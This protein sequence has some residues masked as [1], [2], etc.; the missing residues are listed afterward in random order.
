M[1]TLRHVGGVLTSRCWFVVF[2]LLLGVSLLT[3]GCQRE[4]R[5]ESSVLMRIGDRTITVDEYQRDFNLYR[6]ATGAGPGEDAAGDRE[7]QIRFVRQ[8]VDQLVLLEHARTIGIDVT[9]QELATALEAI[10]RD[11]PD[12]VFEQLLLENAVTLEEWKASLRNRLIIERVIRQE[13]EEDIRIREEDMAQFM[14]Q[15][16]DDRRTDGPVDETD[17]AQTPPSDE[18][19]VDQLRRS[20]TESA[21]A[22]WFTGLKKQYPVE[23]N[24]AVLTEVLSATADGRE[25]SDRDLSPAPQR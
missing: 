5:L 11:Y 1:N 22:E 6:S 24:Q 19:I 7:T 15:L 20:K 13:L 17:A 16:R 14:A 9:D 25:A 4:D 23:I 3:V 18:S 21:Y 12:D 10:Q 2:G 8:L